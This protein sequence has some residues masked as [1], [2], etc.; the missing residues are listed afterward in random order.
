MAVAQEPRDG[1]IVAK[2]DELAKKM[3]TTIAAVAL[4]WLRGHGSLPIASART[5]VQAK[6]IF[7][8]IELA[9]EDL[10]VLD[11]LSA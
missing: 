11:E 5:A 10:H 1:F 4:A 3:D 8:I 6:E 7:P 2:L 9:K